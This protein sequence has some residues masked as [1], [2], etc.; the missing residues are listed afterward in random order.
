MLN[1]HQN[2]EKYKLVADGG[3]WEH[4]HKALQVRG[5]KSFRATCMKGHG[6]EVN[7]SRGI[8]PQKDKEGND[9]A[10]QIADIGAKLHWEDS[11]KDAQ[12]VGCRHQT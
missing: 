11:V 7:M 3:L 5:P 1:G 4:F 12:G 10:D 2:L 6:V 8:T 9:H